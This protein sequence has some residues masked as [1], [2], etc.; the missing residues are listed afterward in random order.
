MRVLLVQSPVGRKEAPIYPIGLACLA[1]SLV[2]HQCS[3]LDLSLQESPGDAL[4][5]ELE[6]FAPDVVAISVRNIDDSSYPVTHWY[7]NSLDEILGALGN[8][9]GTVVVGGAGFSIYPER[10]MKLWPRIDFAMV[11]E[12]EI[13]LPMLLAH[14]AGAPAPEW[15][16]NGVARPPRPSLEDLSLPDYSVFPASDYPGKGSVGVQTRRGC[17]FNCAYCTYKSLSGNGFRLRPVSS[18]VQDIQEVTRQGFTSFMFVDSVFDYPR[19]YF[20]ELI[21]ALGEIRNIPAWGAWMSES[22][23]LDSL[24]TMYRAGCRWVDFSPDVIT[25]K[26]W[27]L[28]GKSGSLKQLWPVVKKARAAGLTVGINFFSASPGENLIALIMKFVF[29]LR[30]RLFLGWRNTFINIGTI[31]LYKDA[32]LSDQ[33]YPGEELFEPVFYRPR[34]L[35]DMIVRAFQAVRRFHHGN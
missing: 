4:A 34:G 14:I 12:G 16:H 18:V 27:K 17:V 26:G 3:G 10:I 35:A 28:M 1:G 20:K 24:D 5:A 25:E 31:R 32:P 33:L 22:V 21:S 11:G 2:D 30:A 9:K 19:V 7:L 13:A 15:L 8:W 29:M 23:P 6:V